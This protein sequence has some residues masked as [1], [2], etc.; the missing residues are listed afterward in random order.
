MSE[1]GLI[2]SNTKGLAPYGEEAEIRIIADRI[3]RVTPG[4]QNLND[5]QCLALAQVAYT[6]D[7]NPTI[8]EIQFLVRPNG[9]PMGFHLGIPLYRR[10]ARES[11]DREGDDYWIEQDPIL[12]KEV[13][14]KYKLDANDL[15]VETLVYRQ[16]QTKAWAEIST[17]L[18]SS[19]APW[20]FIEAQLGKKPFYRGIGVVTV[21]EMTFRESKG[22]HKTYSHYELGCKRSETAALKKAFHLDFGAAEQ[23]ALE[24]DLELENYD[25]IEGSWTDPEQEKLRKEAEKLRKD[26]EGLSSEE[27]KEKAEQAKSTLFESP[28]EK[29]TKSTHGRPYPPEKLKERIT[30]FIPEFKGARKDEKRGTMT[31][32]QYVAWQMN[33]C[34]RGDPEPDN[35]RHAALAYLFDGKTSTNDLSGAELKAVEKWLDPKEWEGEGAGLYPC[36]EARLEARSLVVARIKEQGQAEMSL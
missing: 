7:A 18:A 35:N 34:Y 30:E 24:L 28:D 12:G 10:K 13:K 14:A 25:V 20:E 5:D 1:K 33:E 15:V 16:S 29:P 19:G 9:T 3:R 22:M 4:A 23:K 11:C 6:I 31:L 32:V 36:K 8:G 2:K 27:R 17:T 21:Q 26:W